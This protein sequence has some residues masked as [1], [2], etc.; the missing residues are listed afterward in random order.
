MQALINKYYFDLV[1]LLE[2]NTP[3]VADDLRSFVDPAERKP[4]QRLLETVLCA[5][6]ID[7]MHAEP[8]DYDKPLLLCVDL[9]KQLLAIPEHKPIIS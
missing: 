3:W 2:N 6:N 9:I 7:Y 1:I 5:N 8:S 4:L